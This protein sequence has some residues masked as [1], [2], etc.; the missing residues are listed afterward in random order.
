[1]SAAALRSVVSRIDE[2]FAWLAVHPPTDDA[3]HAAAAALASARAVLDLGRGPDAS[4]RAR[5]DLPGVAARLPEIDAELAGHLR[6]IEQAWAR[7]TPR[8]RGPRRQR[9]PA[10]PPRFFLAGDRPVRT[11]PMADG[12]LDVLAFDWS[13]GRLV[14]DM[15]QLDVLAPGDRDVDEIDAAAFFAAVDRLRRARGLPTPPRPT[16][17]DALGADLD[18][19]A[20]SDAEFPY[21]VA[22]S[23]DEWVVRVD[24][25]PDDPHVYTLLINGAEAFGFDAWP[26]TWSRP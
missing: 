15:T 22:V 12:G 19:L 24:D 9:G 25:W 6:A 11:V 3:G 5:L 2:A 21:R 1:M 17:A 18:W 16:P 4:E 10:K 23:G 7:L 14:R 26:D 20:T 8:T 13:T